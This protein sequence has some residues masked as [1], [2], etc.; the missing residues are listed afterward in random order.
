MKKSCLTAVSLA[1]LTFPTFAS[2]QSSM[3]LSGSF[4]V[5]EQGAATYTL[6]IDAP[7]ARGGIQPSV[8]LSY[9]SGGGESIMGMGWG[10]SGLSAISRCPKTIEQDGLL[11]GVELTNSDRYCLDGSRLMLVSGSHGQDGA[12]YRKEVDDASIV[13]VLGQAPGGG[14]G[15]F[16][17]ESKSGDTFYYGD[18]NE[19]SGKHFSDV[20]GNKGDDGYRT[21]LK[22]NLDVIYQWNLKAIEDPVGNYISYHYQ[23]TATEQYLKSIDYAGHSDGQLPYQQIHFVYQSVSNPKYGFVYGSPVTLTQR[24]H[25]VEVRLDDAV[26][27]TWYLT[28]RDATSGTPQN[29]LDQIQACLGTSQTDCSTPVS[30]EWSR[31]EPTNASGS[32]TPFM[33]KT[34][35]GIPSGD[36]DTAKFFDMD[37][38]GRTDIVYVRNGRWYKRTVSGGE[39]SLTTTGASQSAF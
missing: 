9:T 36:N 29:Y 17:V 5:N 4:R 10:L 27:K 37:G 25:K 20:Q 11:N 12:Q 8:E 21:A 7:A 2:T 39:A 30:F 28:Y 32:Y 13:T 18:M 6:P 16:M 24:L 26:S 3:P 35:L 15:A 19:V 14:P 1:L 31:P 23:A 38:D 22:N 34:A 33:A